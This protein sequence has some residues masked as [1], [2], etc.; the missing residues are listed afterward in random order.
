MDKAKIAWLWLIR[1]YEPVSVAELIKMLVE[2][3]AKLPAELADF[4]YPTYLQRAGKD[5]VKALIDA[6]LVKT[7]SKEPYSGHAKL[8]RT[9]TLDQVQD[10]F[11][12]SLTNSLTR[13]DT[14]LLV[15]PVF[16]K[17]AEKTGDWARLF[18]AMPFKPELKPV[19]TDHILKVA[20]A[21]GLSCKRGDD[22]FTTNHIMQDVWSAIYH[23]E[24]CIVDCTDR[25]AN[26]FYELGMAHTL[27]RKTVLITQKL[28]DIPFDVRS[29]RVIEYTYT[30]PG[31]QKFEMDLTK[32]LQT[33]LD[34]N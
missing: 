27:G 17:P 30:P 16:G 7:Q 18:V 24:L 14:S 6:G 5:S 4:S 2:G 15:D 28:N 22:F 25:N 8:I 32:T 21:L 12:I 19:Y 1:E 9:K 23:A 34:N 3:E 29:Y 26:V 13:R 31:M 11:S 33:E 10:I 20:S